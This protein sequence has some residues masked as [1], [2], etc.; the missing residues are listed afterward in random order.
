MII[1]AWSVIYIAT[2]EST[3][4]TQDAFSRTYLVL[5]SNPEQDS[6]ATQFGNSL[7]NGL[8]IVGVIC[9]LT[10]L[11][12]ILYH[13][14]CLTCL[15]GYMM[16]SSG[17]LLGYLASVMFQ[18]AIDRYELG[19][20]KLTFAVTMFNFAV[21]GVIAIFSGAF[22]T[23]DSNSIVPMYISQSYLV[24]TSVIIAWQLSHFDPWTSWV[25]LVLLALY[26]WCA[27]LTPCG[28]L[29][30]LVRLMQ[31]D[32]A[33]AMPGLLYEAN[34]PVIG[35]P[36]DSTA[37]GRRA[38]AAARTSG[39]PASS[40]PPNLQSDPARAT[41]GG[42]DTAVPLPRAEEPVFSFPDVVP[43]PIGTAGPTQPH[44]S[45]TSTTASIYDHGD[46]PQQSADNH[47]NVGSAIYQRWLPHPDDATWRTGFIPLAL[48]ILYKLPFRPEDPHI[49]WIVYTGRRGV[50]SSEPPDATTVPRSITEFT[51][52]QLQQLVEVVFPSTGGSIVP[53][54][55]CPETAYTYRRTPTAQE[56]RY[57]VIDHRGV[58]KRV[59]FVN[60]EGR[61]FQDMRGEE[62]SEERKARTSIKLGLGDFIFYSILVSKA[63][64]YGY[65]TFVVCTLAV[66]SGL[67]LTLLLLA[68][69]GHALPAL[70]ISIL[71]GVIFYLLTRY[72]IE[73]WVEAFFIFRVYA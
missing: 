28:P 5:D 70:P 3:A 71:L 12:V 46:A 39:N 44:E 30:A 2:P 10:F 66:L 13:L 47:V 36:C 9:A 37:A 16:L 67:G 41:D 43:H 62:S 63:A 19:I 6:N 54:D 24:L 69:Y 25:L 40:P 15:M 49:P 23:T 34:L 27:V 38:T 1:T 11:I 26:D 59:L 58:V 50:S 32:D 35:V 72:V 18:V 31:R 33:P 61:I 68:V 21:V 65:T 45:I 14:R 51:P 17:L 7:V 55:E 8:V 64:L 73:P 4:A 53:I 57:A 22:G 29:R 56:R 60:A 20:D 42:D 52:Q 48:A